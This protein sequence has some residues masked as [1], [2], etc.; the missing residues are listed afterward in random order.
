MN[1]NDNVIAPA[2]KGME[3]QF[4]AIVHM[5]ILLLSVNFGCFSS[6]E[7]KDDDIILSKQVCKR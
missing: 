4:L 7:G 3:F 2:L 1:V 5:L 6:Q